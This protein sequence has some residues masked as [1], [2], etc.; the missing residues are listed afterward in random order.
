MA[1]VKRERVF[2]LTMSGDETLELDLLAE[3]LKLSKADTVRLGLKQ[4]MA[5]CK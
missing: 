2:T 1:K 3:H 4:L 5:Q